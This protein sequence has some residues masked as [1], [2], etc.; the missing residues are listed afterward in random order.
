MEPLRIRTPPDQNGARVSVARLV[1]RSVLNILFVS[2]IPCISALNCF[3]QPTDRHHHQSP[4][5][6]SRPRGFSEIWSLI[7]TS[8]ERF[9]FCCWAEYLSHRARSEN[10]TH[11]RPLDSNMA[12]ASVFFRRL[13]KAVLLLNWGPVIFGKLSEVCQISV[14]KLSVTKMCRKSVRKLSDIYQKTVRLRTLSENCQMRF[15]IVLEI[16]QN[17]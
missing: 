3:N 16:W 12:G 9:V 5:T 14:R 4:R 10:A 6:A 15:G 8:D 2:T 7:L 13:K 11:F 1:L 17:L